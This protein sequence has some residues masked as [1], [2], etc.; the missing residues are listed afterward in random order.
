MIS[1]NSP[2]L[3]PSK[4]RGLKA[5][6]FQSRAAG[7][8]KSPTVVAS[9]RADSSGLS[10]GRSRPRSPSPAFGV[11]NDEHA[12]ASVR[13]AGIGSSYNSPSCRHPHA[14]KVS[15]D[16]GKPKRPVSVHV[17][18]HGDP[19]PCAGRPSEGHRQ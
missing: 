6:S 5:W 18:K 12:L 8:G 15:K 14:G 11:G 16:I 10:R 17:P 1:G 19:P 2:W 7:V 9:S 4:S 13:S 3:R